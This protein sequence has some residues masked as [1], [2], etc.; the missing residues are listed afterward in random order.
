MY[1]R[2]VNHHKLL[3][4]IWVWTTNTAADALDWYPG[5][6]IVDIVG[7]DIYPQA[8]DHNAQSVAFEA[9]KD[10]YKAKKIIALS[11]CGSIPAAADMVSSGATWSYFMPW[12]REYV[13]PNGNPPHNSEAFWK[14]QMSSSFVISLEQIP[15]W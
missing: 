8:G 5:D 9:A 10:I 3:N 11:E 1:D 2:F 14:T 7:Q 6:D 15:G 4:L 13:I 12:Y